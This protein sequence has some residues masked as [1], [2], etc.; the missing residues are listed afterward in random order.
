MTHI[1]QGQM[2]AL[3]AIYIDKNRN[4]PKGMVLEVVGFSRDFVLLEN[5]DGVIELNIQVF[6]QFCLWVA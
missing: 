6:N 1:E 2:Y 3:T 5:N 4:I